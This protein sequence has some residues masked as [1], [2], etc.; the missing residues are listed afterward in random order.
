[1]YNPTP[2]LFRHFHGFEFQIHVVCAEHDAGPYFPAKE[3]NAS[4]K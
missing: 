4:F 3:E 1:M 2:N